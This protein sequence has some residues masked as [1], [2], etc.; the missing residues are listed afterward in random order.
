MQWQPYVQKYFDIVASQ[1]S[2]SD[3]N[4]YTHVNVWP[5]QRVY[6]S[7]RWQVTMGVDADIWAFRRR[8]MDGY[9]SPLLFNGYEGTVQLYYTQSENIG[10]SLWGGFGMQK[11]ELFP[12]YFYEEDLGLQLFFGIYKDLELKIKGGYTLRDNPSHHNY[13]FWSGGAV[14]TKRF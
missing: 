12:H 8:A 9:Y 4:S 3:N 14:L 11:D 5:K 6:N 1:S 13:Q 10:Y 7:E 2:L